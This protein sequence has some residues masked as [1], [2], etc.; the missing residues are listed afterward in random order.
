RMPGARFFPAARLNFAENLLW[1]TGDTDAIVFR[2]EDAYHARF[3]WDELRALVSRLQQAFA[4]AGVRPG[5]RVAAMLPNVPE[6]IACMLAAA[7]L[8]AIWSSCSP[9]FGKQGVLDRFA[10]IEPKLFIACDGYRYNGTTFDIGDK[11]A[12][13]AGELKPAHTI[14]VRY[15]R[16][17]QA[18]AADIP[19]ARSLEALI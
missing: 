16:D 12:A 18:V 15:V 14:V 7:S 6:A 19:G 5:N 3:S 17:A 13:I 8:G 11:V 9:D 1:K 10:Q 2:G 4:D